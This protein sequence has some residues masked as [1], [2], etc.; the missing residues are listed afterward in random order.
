M[1]VSDAA[2]GGQSGWNAHQKKVAAQT[3]GD[4]Q[5]LIDNQQVEDYVSARP[6]QRPARWPRPTAKF[7]GDCTGTIKLVVHDWNGIPIF[8]GEPSGYGDTRSFATSPHVYHVQ[9]LEHAQ[10]LDICLYKHHDGGW[11]GGPNEHATILTH[12]VGGVWHAFSMG[13]TPGPSNIVAASIHD[14]DL[15]IR[16]RIPLK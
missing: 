7:V 13:S 1:K 4:L 2:S 5:W 3:L 12:K 11:Q 10:P 8:D 15:I 14:L 9:G 16:F 6:Y